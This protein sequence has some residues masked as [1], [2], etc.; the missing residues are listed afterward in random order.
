[1]LLLLLLPLLVKSAALKEASAF[2]VQMIHLKLTPSKKDDSTS[3]GSS[4]SG[5]GGNLG[6]MSSPAFGSQQSQSGG[7]GGGNTQRNASGTSPSL[8]GSSGS[9]S[10]G[11]ST[12]NNQSGSG[13]SLPP[14]PHPSPL[15]LP[16]PYS[17]TPALVQPLPTENLLNNLTY[18]LVGPVQHA[19]AMLHGHPAISGGAGEKNNNSSS[20]SST[21]LSSLSRADLGI[22]PMNLAPSALAPLGKKVSS[23]AAAVAAA[24]NHPFASIP[25]PQELL[26][27]SVTPILV[28]PPRPELANEMLDFRR[29]FPGPPSEYNLESCEKLMR[30]HI[31]CI[32]DWSKSKNAL[33]TELYE[34]VDQLL[35]RADA[36]LKK[37]EGKLRRGHFEV[38]ATPIDRRRGPGAL[39]AAGANTAAAASSAATTA[40]GASAGATASPAGGAP[41]PADTRKRSHA[42]LV[43][44]LESREIQYQLQH[45][46]KSEIDKQSASALASANA[47]S[48][49]T[50]GSAGTSMGNMMV[51]AN[52]P[53]YCTCKKVSFGAMVACKKEQ[54]RT[55]PQPTREGR[56]RPPAYSLARVSLVVPV[57]AASAQATTK[58][59]PPNGFI[60]RAWGW[61]RSRVVNGCAPTVA[62]R[63][64]PKR[65]RRRASK[66]FTLGA[67][68]RSR[69]S[70]SSLPNLIQLFQSFASSDTVYSNVCHMI[71]AAS[72]SRIEVG[73]AIER[74]V[75]KG[76]LICLDLWSVV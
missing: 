31:A 12:T 10:G 21:S 4:A 38:P 67:H 22:L 41:V 3:A 17:L 7:G 11:G 44:D 55:T 29:R 2:H 28:D 53:V 68:S 15:P 52:E 66:C 63:R 6:G 18:L 34:Q 51:E 73:A 23:S 25:S 74:S 42:S 48:G 27:T 65:R 43:Q 46:L 20:S 8:Y 19:Q 39:G 30:D 33:V 32:H 13:S 37:Y 69:L 26:A 56:P 47:G 58:I 5:S 49:T 71:S 72:N 24:A 16:L 54:Q 45:E 76:V 64:K 70:R 59:V 57:C 75:S 35:K 62:R 36:A 50:V 60:S 14:L 61:T 9:G 40:A 1:M